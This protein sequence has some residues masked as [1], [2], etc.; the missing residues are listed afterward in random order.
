MRLFKITNGF[1]Q[2]IDA[3]LLVRAKNIR[4]GVANHADYFPSPSPSMN[5]IDDSITA[6]TAALLAAEGGNRLKVA[7]KAAARQTLITNLHLLGN[8]VLYRAEGNEVI[9]K[10]S[11]FNISRQP[12]PRPSLTVPQGLALSNGLNKGELKLKFKRVAGATAY[13]YEITPS[14]VT[15]DSVWDSSMN[16]VSKKMFAG[17]ESGKEYNCR[18]AAI[19][20]KEQVIYSEAVSRIAL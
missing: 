8:Y 11:N 9:A 5:A 15:E 13:L 1:D 17:L 18:V 7:E 4:A 2:M 14:P 6:F 3:L 19:G 20:I 16:T 12:T 10:S